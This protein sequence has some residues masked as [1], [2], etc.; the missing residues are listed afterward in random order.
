MRPKT[1]VGCLLNFPASWAALAPAMH[2]APHFKPP[3]H[4]VLYLKPVNTHR[5]SGEAIVLPAGVDE[6]EVG[7]TVGVV[8]G[9]SASRLSEQEALRFVAG[10]V[11]VNDVTVPHTAVLR[12]PI[13]QKCRDSFCPMG[14]PVPASAV[15]DC[16]QLE[17]RVEV[18]GERQVVGNTRELLRSVPRLLAEVTEF[19]TLEAG[20][21]L[22]VGVPHDVPRARA[23]DRVAVDIAGV[24]R[25]ENTLRAQG[26]AS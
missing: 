19:M 24:G 4:P 1:V 20:D 15:A 13:K 18:N 7:A 3:Q 26:G 25:V 10:Y 23:G 2:E 21:V 22:L 11:P 14:E 17:I 6:V 8:I 9:A 5:R 16:G 12:P